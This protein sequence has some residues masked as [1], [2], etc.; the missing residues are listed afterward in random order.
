MQPTFL[1]SVQRIKRCGFQLGD[2]L[3]QFPNQTM[4]SIGLFTI[5]SFPCPLHYC[6]LF[7]GDRRGKKIKKRKTTIIEGPHK[8][9]ADF[10]KIYGMVLKFL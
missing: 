4:A 9:A 6:P 5:P 7:S 8:F 2:F 10:L 1:R 3:Q